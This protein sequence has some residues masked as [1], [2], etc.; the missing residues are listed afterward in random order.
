[1][2]Y[3][4]RLKRLGNVGT[5]LL[6]YTSRYNINTFRVDYDC[7]VKREEASCR[8]KLIYEFYYAFA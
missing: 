3:G 8:H 4:Q 2:D 1:M 6:D 5:L 7:C